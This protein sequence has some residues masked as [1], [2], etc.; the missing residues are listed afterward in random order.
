MRARPKMEEDTGFE[1]LNICSKTFI[2][3]NIFVYGRPSR[4]FRFPLFNLKSALFDQSHEKIALDL[5]NFLHLHLAPSF[6]LIHSYI[7]IFN[8]Q[9]FF[10]FIITIVPK[11]LITAVWF[12]LE[13][14]TELQ[15]TAG[16][17]IVV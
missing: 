14:A 6:T 16:I 8:F 4:S 7:F 1:T 11:T 13:N 9:I 3:N 17:P 2:T 5:F 12:P 10:S 15:P